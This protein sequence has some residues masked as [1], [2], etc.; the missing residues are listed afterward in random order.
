[1]AH[2]NRTDWPTLEQSTVPTTKRLIPH[3]RTDSSLD[4]K[5]PGFVPQVPRFSSISPEVEKPSLVPQNRHQIKQQSRYFQQ[6]SLLKPLYSCDTRA[7]LASRDHASLDFI[8]DPRDER[9]P[10]SQNPRPSRDPRDQ[11]NSPLQYPLDLFNQHDSL[12]SH[13][14]NPQHRL[15]PGAS[16]FLKGNL[17]INM[18]EGQE[19]ESQKY[20]KNGRTARWRER[21]T[22]EKSQFLQHASATPYPAH[23]DPAHNLCI[24]G[25]QNLKAHELRSTNV[26]ETQWTVHDANIFPTYARNVFDR[27]NRNWVNGSEIHDDG[28]DRATF[29]LQHRVALNRTHLKEPKTPIKP[30]ARLLHE[31]IREQ[32]FSVYRPTVRLTE[33]MSGYARRVAEMNE[34]DEEDLELLMQ[35]KEPGMKVK[36]I[37][38]VYQGV[39]YGEAFDNYHYQ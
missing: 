23:E 11:R 26:D 27:P 29:E 25:E 12:H 28:N 22:F 34:M 33:S 21:K 30:I 8:E 3:S 2:L 13:L 7:Q 24:F 31:E 6:R 18:Q 35:D 17:R 38:L 32:W 5:A 16:T 1:M 9:A 20:G 39:S 36:E 19:P 15:N 10:R 14:Q 37:V 4:P